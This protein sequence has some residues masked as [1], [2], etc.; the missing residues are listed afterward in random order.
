M[1][2]KSN[3]SRLVRRAHT[4]QILHA[5]TYQHRG[6]YKCNSVDLNEQ[7]QESSCRQTN[8][9]A[10]RKEKF[11]H[12]VYGHSIALT[13]QPRIEKISRGIGHHSTPLEISKHATALHSLTRSVKTIK[14]RQHKLALIPYIE[15][16]GL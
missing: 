4:S 10:Q 2:R 1:K 11:R 3:T 12:Q 16:T 7:K 6:E 5:R 13:L 14:E 8:G 9:V 15:Q